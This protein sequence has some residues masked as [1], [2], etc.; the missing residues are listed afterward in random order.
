MANALNKFQ[1]E[2]S[3]ETIE[4]LASGANQIFI[5]GRFSTEQSIQEALRRGAEGDFSFASTRLS[6]IRAT[7]EKRG[8]AEGHEALQQD[9]KI[10]KTY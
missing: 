2:F 6:Q 10:L 4:R 3:P 8:E 5:Q 7:L 1:F 9:A